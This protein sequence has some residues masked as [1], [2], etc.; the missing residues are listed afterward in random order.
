MRIESKSLTVITFVRV[1]FKLPKLLLES[2]IR[3]SP[4]VKRRNITKKIV[5]YSIG[6]GLLQYRGIPRKV[7]EALIS[8]AIYHCDT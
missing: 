5:K 8:K 2:Q 4:L 1:T 6:K 7:E 3:N